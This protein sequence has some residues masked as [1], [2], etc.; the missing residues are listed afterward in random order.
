MLNV[1]ALV[2]HVVCVKK[3]VPRAICVTILAF[4]EMKVCTQICLKMSKRHD[5]DLLREARGCLKVFDAN[6]EIVDD[7]VACTGILSRKNITVFFYDD[8]SF[9]VMVDDVCVYHHIV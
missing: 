2:L 6:G 4:L 3:R 8:N 7:L 5:F 9:Q 1:C